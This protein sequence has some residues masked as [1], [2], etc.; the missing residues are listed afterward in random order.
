MTRRVF[1]CFHREDFWRA[2]QVINCWVSSGGE[3]AGFIDDAGWEALR[4]QGDEAVKRWI[5]SKLEG[6]SAT[7]V[8]IGA[9]TS[10]IEWVRYEIRR[11]HEKGNGLLGIHIN[12]LKDQNGN[13]GRQG[14]DHF[15]PI[16]KA[17][18]GNDVYFWQLYPTY[19]WV[20]DNGDHNLGDW[21]KE[22]VGK[23]RLRQSEKPICKR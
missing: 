7:V 2:G 16:A 3:E 12:N 9:E 15:G 14:D 22:A 21:V 18:T 8:L 17:C 10:S 23:A 11:S 6:T 4:K 1:F 13:R 5:N 20:N 19:D